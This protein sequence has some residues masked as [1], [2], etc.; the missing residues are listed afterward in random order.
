VAKSDT[1]RLAAMRKCYDSK[2]TGENKVSR[3]TFN[4][5]YAAFYRI[6]HETLV[7]KKS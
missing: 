1:T 4:T 7:K 6:H 3:S 2:G 5:N